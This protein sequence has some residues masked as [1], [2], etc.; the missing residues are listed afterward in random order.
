MTIKELTELQRLAPKEIYLQILG[1]ERQY[2]ELRD[3]VIDWHE[4]ISWCAD[5]INDTD[6]RYVRVLTRRKK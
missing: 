3:H 2:L 6:V 1:E 4:E 5:Q